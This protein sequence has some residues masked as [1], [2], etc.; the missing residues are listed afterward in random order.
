LEGELLYFKGKKKECY[1]CQLKIV[2]EGSLDALVTEN[3]ALM[4]PTNANNQQL[5]AAAEIKVMVNA[6][7]QLIIY[8]SDNRKATK[9]AIFMDDVKQLSI[10]N[11]L[12]WEVIDSN[13]RFRLKVANSSQNAKWYFLIYRS[14]LERKRFRDRSNQPQ[15]NPMLESDDEEIDTELPDRDDPYF[16]WFQIDQ[17]FT[18]PQILRFFNNYK[19]DIFELKIHRMEISIKKVNG[20]VSFMF[21]MG[22]KSRL[23]SLLEMN[24][25]VYRKTKLIFFFISY[26]I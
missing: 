7:D 9:A 15:Y 16:N 6:D 13:K 4:T 12:S 25:S 26:F 17:K 14:M 5:A 1:P 23:F 24:Y 11:D 19:S 18:S 21:P 20:P 10:N 22:Y 8:R 3:N 2:F